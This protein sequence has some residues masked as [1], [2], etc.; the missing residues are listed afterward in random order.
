MEFT[1]EEIYRIAQSGIAQ[2][3]CGM[4]FEELVIE[5]HIRMPNLREEEVRHVLLELLG[6]DA[7]PTDSGKEN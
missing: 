5:A 6:R 3:Y 4:T 7:A 2:V 1:E